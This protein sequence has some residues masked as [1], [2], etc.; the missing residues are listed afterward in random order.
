MGSGPTGST[1]GPDLRATADSFTKM[2]TRCSEGLTKQAE[3]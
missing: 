3:D 2:S 1:E